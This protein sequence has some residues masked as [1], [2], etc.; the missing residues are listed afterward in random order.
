MLGQDLFIG[1]VSH[2]RTAYKVNQGPEGLAAKLATELRRQGTP[3]SFEVNTDNCFEQSGIR[4]NGAVFRRGI[5]EELRV[6]N[7]WKTFMGTPR[8]L[9]G[10]VKHMARW[11]RVQT[12]RFR[13]PDLSEVK[14]LVNIEMS[15]IALMRKGLDSGAQW[16]LILEDDAGC[17]QIDEL[18]RGIHE[19]LGSGLPMSYVNLSDSFSL[20]ELEVE[21]LLTPSSRFSWPGSHDRIVL[22]S[23]K[24]ATN[25]VCAILYRSSFLGGLVD[26]LTAIPTEPLLPIDWKLNLALVA[27]WERGEVGP[28]D[29]WFIDPGPIVQLSMHDLS[30]Q[31]HQ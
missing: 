28:G 27:M 29:C 10:S 14:R 12:Y 9:K 5:A 15:H 25:T 4:S 31:D 11:I 1:V 20:S 7:V 13:K 16:V 24:P 6:E 26:S 17:N 3:C 2:P 22:E 21:H 8:S 19:I 30:S 23:K 18:A